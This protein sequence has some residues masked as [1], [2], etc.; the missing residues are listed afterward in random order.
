LLAD[1][2]LWLTSLGETDLDISITAFKAIATGAKSFQ[3]QLARAA[4]RKKFDGLAAQL[5]PLVAH[6]QAA[7]EHLSAVYPH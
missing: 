7:F 4:A 5:D 6:Y 1:H 3:F 2:L